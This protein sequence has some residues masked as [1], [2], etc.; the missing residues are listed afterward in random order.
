MLKE[1]EGLPAPGPCLTA[2]DGPGQGLR[3]PA[4]AASG[5]REVSGSAGS[6]LGRQ[7]EDGEYARADA[8]V[9]TWWGQALPGLGQG[10]GPTRPQRP[11]DRERPLG[12]RKP[13]TCPEC[14]KTFSKTSHLTKH[15]RTHTGERP[16]QCQVCGKRFGDRSNCST[17]QR[18]HTGE[19]PYACAQCGK[20]FSQSSS[21]VIHRRTHTG[22]RPYACT[23][24][25]K[26]FNNSSHFSA[27]RRTHTGEKPHTCPACG[28]GFRRGTDLRKHQR[29]HGGEQ[30]LH[31]PQRLQD[32]PGARA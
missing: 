32:A 20:R 13:H 11:P 6:E 2:Q 5:L 16:Y 29:T 15:Q 22:E 27:H 19:K 18:V 14:G 26:R 4:C 9:R 17:H 10:P 12:V 31:R 24:C 30:P 8:S 23:E 28:R 21:L 7:F 1:D 3:D 25:G